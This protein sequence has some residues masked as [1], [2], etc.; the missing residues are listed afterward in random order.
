MGLGAET[1]AC[2]YNRSG[3]AGL[4]FFHF[5]IVGKTEGPFGVGI[6]VPL[7]V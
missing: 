3:S 2:W 1:N 7:V 4:T 6:A 5:D